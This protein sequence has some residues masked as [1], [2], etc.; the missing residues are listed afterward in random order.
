[1]KIKINNKSYE[2]KEQNSLTILQVCDLVNIHIPR[3][4]Y[5][6]KLS[7]AGNCRMCFV[8][9]PKSKK[10]VLACS[11]IITNEMSIYTNTYMVKKAQ[12][13]ALE[14][15]LV[16]HP[17]DCPIC[18]QGG[19]CDLQELT[20]NFGNDRGRFKEIKRS[21]E[22]LQLGSTI[23][24]IMTR[25]IH[26]TRCIRFSS[27]VLNLPVLGTAGRGRDTEVSLYVNKIIHSE[28]SGNLVD[29]CPV[30]ALTSKPYA[31]TARP[32]EL[33]HTESID[34]LDSFGSSIRIDT[35]GD[36]VMRILPKLNDDLN[37]EWITDKIRFTYDSFRLQ[38]YTMPSFLQKQWL[39]KLNN[40]Y[41]N[42]GWQ[43]IFNLLEKYFIYFN[44]KN[45]IFNSGNLVDL[46]SLFLFNKLSNT[47]AAKYKNI[48]NHNNDFR[49]NYL[50]NDTNIDN[51]QYYLIIGSNLNF[52]NAMLNFKLQKNY[53]RNNKIINYVGSKWSNIYNQIALTNKFIVSLVKGSHTDSFNFFKLD[54]IKVLL[55]QSDYNYSFLFER[56][57]T[58]LSLFKKNYSFHYL[59]N[60]LGY[61]H[62]HFGTLHNSELGFKNT[63]YS[64][65]KYIN[66]SILNKNSI[67]YNFSTHINYNQPNSMTEYDFNINKNENSFFIFQGHHKPMIDNNLYNVIIPNNLFIES[68]NYFINN[69]GMLLHTN[70]A[71]NLPGLAKLNTDILNQLIEDFNLSK[72]RNLNL[73]ISNFKLYNSTSV[74]QNYKISIPFKSF[75]FFHDS[76]LITTN[77]PMM[78]KLIKEKKKI[79]NN[80]NKTW[81]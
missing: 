6:E 52:E 68:H 2:I 5:H 81:Q 12:E 63:N 39:N 21:V 55:K 75:Y 74:F 72:F 22:D 50:L 37:E 23:K 40:N 16:N 33:K 71:T 3:F 19:E 26:C 62:S 53:K 49:S 59:N 60:Y 48:Q 67:S 65:N 80:Y 35:K 4:C 77:S 70:K 29:L 43:F 7:I 10:P 41:I 54:N 45:I 32:W 28:L 36:E 25:C 13:S 66:N 9:I 42:T 31:F 15:L 57:N 61:I 14:F 27:E 11:T 76:D 18:D 44:S 30:G 79:I 46:Q 73:E 34:V 8:E 56:M 51:K 47:L 64:S 69:F 1:M 17:L 78:I 24:T 20:K 58:F 38:R